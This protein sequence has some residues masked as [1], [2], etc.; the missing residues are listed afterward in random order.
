M[1]GFKNLMFHIPTR[2]SSKKGN[3]MKSL[4]L[5][6]DAFQS[7]TK[8]SS[9]TIFHFLQHISLRYFNKPTH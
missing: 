2:T 7:A 6:F 1:E 4:R 5:E 3:R 8:V 9:K